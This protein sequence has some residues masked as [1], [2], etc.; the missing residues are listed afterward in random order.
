MILFRSIGSTL[1]TVVFLALGEA[2]A[3]EAKRPNI[4]FLMADHLGCMDLACQGNKL[5][6]TP[7]LD[8]LARQG[9][10]SPVLMRRHRFVLPQGPLCSQGR[11]QP[12]SA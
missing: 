3:A 12:G 5:V 1:A 10:A 7:N 8:R 9:C 11:L 4:L 6:E 2:R